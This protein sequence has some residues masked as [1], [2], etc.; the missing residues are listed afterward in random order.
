[1]SLIVNQTIYGQI[2]VMRFTSGY[3]YST[4]KVEKSFVTERFVRTLKNKIYKHMI[5]VSKHMLYFLCL[6]S[7]LGKEFSYY[8]RTYAEKRDVIHQNA[9]ASK[10]GGES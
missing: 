9:N 4:H 2:N 5:A 8:V 1:M 3:I 6:V 7:S 10:E